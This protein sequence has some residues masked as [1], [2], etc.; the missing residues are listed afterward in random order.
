LSARFLK[1]QFGRTSLIS[2]FQRTA[3]NLVID[4]YFPT[5][6][7]IFS[8]NSRLAYAKKR[9]ITSGLFTGATW[10]VIV[11]QDAM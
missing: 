1:A 10:D 8:D 9:T 11:Y 6:L 7:M 5:L 4:L 3:N 2:L